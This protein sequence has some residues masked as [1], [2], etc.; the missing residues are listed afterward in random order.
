M[1]H[2]LTLIMTHEGERTNEPFSKEVAA[3][4]SHSV[5]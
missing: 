1:T 5:H 2:D 4:F 3:K